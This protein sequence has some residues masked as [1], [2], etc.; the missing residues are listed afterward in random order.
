MKA[1]TSMKSQRIKVQVTTPK[2]AYIP[3]QLN[4]KREDKF[5]V[6]GIRYY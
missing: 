4:K 6:G 2:A 5:T 3:L 1:S